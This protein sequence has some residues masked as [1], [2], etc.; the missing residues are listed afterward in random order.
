MKNINKKDYMRVN[1]K[2]EQRIKNLLERQDA[3]EEAL[4]FNDDSSFEDELDQRIYELKLR[5][6]YR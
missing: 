4:G 2:E 3:L 1:K 6:Q 5:E